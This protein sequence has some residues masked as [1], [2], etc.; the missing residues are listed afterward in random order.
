MRYDNPLKQV[1]KMD[2]VKAADAG[3]QFEVGE[4]FG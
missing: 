4:V 1:K 2:T 3:T